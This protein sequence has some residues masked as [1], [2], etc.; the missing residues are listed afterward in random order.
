MKM[1]KTLALVALGL[2]AASAQANWSIVGNQP[3]TTAKGTFGSETF[4]IAGSSDS[5][6][7]DYNLGS[8][9]TTADNGLTLVSG[10]AFS[11][12]TDDN[13]VILPSGGNLG[14]ATSVELVNLYNA[15]L[16]K[17]P[18]SFISTVNGYSDPTFNNALGVT[19]SWFV[20]LSA[21]PGNY[22]IA[23]ALNE[24]LVGTPSQ[25]QFADPI[26][27]IIVIVPAPEPAQTLAGAMLLGCG[28][29]IFVGR[30]LFKKQ[31]A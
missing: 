11:A 30:R 25:N 13:N 19:V 5:A 8:V 6:A 15:H 3:V 28:G 20:P 24:W 9:A 23:V 1:N 7:A 17:L 12:L 22:S 14:T 10:T 31:S 26:G 16:K 4:V 27:N 21:H 18:G 2:C 29:L